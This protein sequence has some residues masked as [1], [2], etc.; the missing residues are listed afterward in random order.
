MR[1]IIPAVNF[2]LEPLNVVEHMSVPV[3]VSDV[4]FFVL[5]PEGVS[6]FLPAQ[7]ELKKQLLL[8]IRLYD[9]Q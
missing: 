9:C 3:W 7:N 8:S 6:W 5:Y 4:T 2:N 1:F